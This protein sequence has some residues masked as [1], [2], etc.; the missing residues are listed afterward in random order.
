[1]G[2]YKILNAAFQVICYQI[3]PCKSDA[4]MS[5][6]DEGFTAQYAEF[7]KMAAYDDSDDQYTSA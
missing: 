3:A 6:K 2:I 4:I 7:V 5:A 1:M